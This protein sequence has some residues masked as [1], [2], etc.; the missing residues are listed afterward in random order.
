[1]KKTRSLSSKSAFHFFCVVCLKFVSFFAGSGTSL[2]CIFMAMFCL[3]IFGGEK[4]GISLTANVF[5]CLVCIKSY[6]YPFQFHLSILFAN[7]CLK[8]IQNVA[9]FINR[10]CLRRANELQIL[11]LLITRKCML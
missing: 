8:L 6:N 5:L 3:G 11:V 9:Y 4:G 10:Y 7:N 1:M 2:S